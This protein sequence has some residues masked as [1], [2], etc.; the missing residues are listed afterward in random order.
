M[1]QMFYTRECALD[2]ILQRGKEDIH[3]SSTNDEAEFI[4]GIQNRRVS[5]SKLCTYF[6]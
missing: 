1:V 4:E 2:V 6:G 3:E 5:I